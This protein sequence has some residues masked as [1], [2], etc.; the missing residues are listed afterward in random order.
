MCS[1]FF[2]TILALL[3][4]LVGWLAGFMLCYLVSEQLLAVEVISELGFS[5][6]YRIK[7]DITCDITW[8]KEIPTEQSTYRFSSPSVVRPL[9]T[10]NKEPP[11]CF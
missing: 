3:L 5:A 4:W 10:E 11:S 2:F 6:A 9:A 8:V 1:A 7:P